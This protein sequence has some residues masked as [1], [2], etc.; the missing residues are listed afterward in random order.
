M[1]I[2]RTVLNLVRQQSFQTLRLFIR[3]GLRRLELNHIPEGSGLKELTH[4]LAVYH[5]VS[6]IRQQSKWSIVKG[7]FCLLLNARPLCL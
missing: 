5:E 3:R 6:H 4:I 2:P 1:V 7:L